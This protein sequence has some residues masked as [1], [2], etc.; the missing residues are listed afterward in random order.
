VLLSAFFTFLSCSLLATFT[1]TRC[2]P[3]SCNFQAWA[4]LPPFKIDT[5][6][7]RTTSQCFAWVAF[8]SGTG[9]H[10][11]FVVESGVRKA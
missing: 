4:I 5:T 6:A 10:T 1:F 11:I 2:P 9:H 8:L 3:D 7:V